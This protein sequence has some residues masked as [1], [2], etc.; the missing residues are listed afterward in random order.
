MT[1]YRPIA[2][3]LKKLKLPLGRLLP[4]S[5]TETMPKLREIIDEAAPP[6]ITAV[7]DVVSK[8]TEAA[9]IRVNLR[10]VDHKSMR[11]SLEPSTFHA[12][13][14]YEV[15]NPAGVITS[16]S[17]DAIKKAFRNKDSIIFVEGE[18]DLLALPCVMESPPRALVLYG[19]PSEGMV[20]VTVLDEVRKEVAGI[21]R[22]AS[23]EHS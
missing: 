8:E 23:Q 22:R 4:G 10:I 12:S 16:G 15:K 21:L 13:N 11:H 9:G 1:L 17:W 18:E 2:A 5:P 19:Q 20:V 7:G 6:Y 14:V 3:D